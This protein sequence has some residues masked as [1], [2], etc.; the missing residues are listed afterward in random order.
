[1]GY[2]ILKNKEEVLR[3]YKS[4]FSHMMGNVWKLIWKLLVP[5]K[6]KNFMWMACGDNIDTNLNLWKMKL[7][8]SPLCHVCEKDEESVEH[9]LL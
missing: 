8:Q 3:G 7:R 6:V 2:H 5:L 1:M 4:A 9:V